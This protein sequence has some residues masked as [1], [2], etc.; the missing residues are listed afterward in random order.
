M[1]LVA[2]PTLLVALALA[3]ASAD[4]PP[5][6]LFTAKSSKAERP[7]PQGYSMPS[8]SDYECSKAS[9]LSVESKGYKIRSS[10]ASQ[11]L[12]EPALAGFAFG[13]SRPSL[14][15]SVSGQPSSAPSSAPSGKP[16]VHPSASF[17]PSSFSG[18]AEKI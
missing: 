4:D 15:P 3:S 1:K 11:P 6:R 16:S 10:K 17:M 8:G 18:K 12:L 2:A 7:C 13:S 14:R 5:Y 9:K